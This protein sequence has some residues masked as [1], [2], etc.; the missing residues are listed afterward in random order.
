MA[1]SF[2]KIGDVCATFYGDAQKGDIVTISSSNT[3]SK[4]AAGNSIAGVCVDNTNG[5]C[6]VM[7]KGFVTLT[8]SGTAIPVGRQTIVS[9]G[10]NAVKTAD[11]GMSVLVVSADTTTKTIVALI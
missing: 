9:A 11:T 5:K 8:Y 2:D 10:D 1:I 4:A 7:V 3:V 6:T